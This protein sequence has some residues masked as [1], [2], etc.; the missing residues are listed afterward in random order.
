LNANDYV[1]LKQIAEM[2]M[3]EIQK[4]VVYLSLDESDTNLMMAG[5]RLA[6]A[7]Q[8]ELRLLFV[9]NNRESLEKAEAELARYA[10]TI[11]SK[12]AEL[13]VSVSAISH[14]GNNFARILADEMEAIV[15]VAGASRFKELAKPLRKSPIPFL[16]INEKETFDSVFRKVIIPVDMR[17]QNKDSLLWS[18]FFG[19]NNQS[20]II[21]IGA[22]DSN[23]DGRKAVAAHLH[24]L[25]KLLTKTDVPHKI[26][27]GERGSLSIQRE[28]LETAGQL[29][30]DLLILLG[31]SF[32]TWLDLLIGLPEEKIIKSAG[33]L[34]VLVVNPRREA[35]LVCD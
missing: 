23:K 14:P 17:Q 16:F 1:V 6:T 24:S 26:Y 11:S 5:I 32:V 8:K 28:V 30:A 15:L 2:T 22:N 21:A 12:V 35:Y 9:S 10:A 19:R 7:F 3:P 4:I 18:V 34:P 29:H 33:N 25:K 13:T 31:S 20:E 27:R